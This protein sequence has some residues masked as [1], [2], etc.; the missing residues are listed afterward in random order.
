MAVSFSFS[1]DPFGGGL[2]FSN[3]KL[4]QR[5]Q[6]AIS[7][8]LDTNG[9]GIRSPGEE[10]LPGVGI[11][12]GQYGSAEPT[13]DKGHAVV[14]GLNPYEKV[15]ISV[16][17]STLPDPFLM[18]VRKGVVVTPRAGVAAELEIAV[19]PTGE[20]EGVIHGIE[21]TPRAGV[22]L[23][24]IDAAGEVAAAALTE[25]DGFFLF[26]RVA[27]GA[28]RVRLSAASA[29]ALGTAQ[30]LGKVVNLGSGATLAQLGV[31]RLRTSEIAALPTGPPGGSSP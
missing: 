27:Y 30:D 25:Y 21:D 23:E 31:V 5:G 11:T 6:A 22:E 14:E 16:D 17:E 13:D 18:P 7:V 15:L 9:D 10:P 1:Q 3:A 2:R 20:V 28:Y 4:A 8:F 26:E 24:L 29:R 19:A 12:A